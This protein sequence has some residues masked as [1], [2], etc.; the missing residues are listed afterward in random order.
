[1]HLHLLRVMHNTHETIGTLSIDGFH[2][3]YTLED[4]VR[5]PGIKI[6][7]RTAIPAGQYK[8]KVTWSPRF[9]VMMPLLIGNEEFSKRWSGIRIHTGNSHTDTEGCILV[10]QRVVGNQLRESRLAYNELMKQLSGQ[11]EITL[12]ISNGV[13]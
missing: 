8:I 3:C 9:K 7:G 11:P 1:M 5:E 6:T 13:V 4:T 10:G 2:F 12:E